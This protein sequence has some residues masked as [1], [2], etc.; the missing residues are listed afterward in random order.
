MTAALDFICKKIPVGKDLPELR[1]QI[2]DEMAA[3]AKAGRRNYV[4]F[5]EAGAKRLAEITGQQGPK[6]LSWFRR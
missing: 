6:W 2:A 4:D 5:Q 3:C 1:K